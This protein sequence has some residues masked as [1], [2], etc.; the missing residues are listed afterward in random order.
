MDKKIE[1]TALD[2][3]VSGSFVVGYN[4]NLGTH[5]GVVIVG[6]KMS[7]ETIKI[8]NA[9]QDEDAEEF[10]KKLITNKEKSND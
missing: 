2:N 6:Q 1:K 3:Y 4:I 10:Y 5:A 9:F 8:I 7:N